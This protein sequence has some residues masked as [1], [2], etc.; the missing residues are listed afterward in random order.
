ML[1][2]EL[3]DPALLDD[4][5]EGGYIRRQIHPKLPL[6][7]LNYT[8]KAQFE[9]VWNDATR[10][11]RGLIYRTDDDGKRE[12]VARPFEKFFNYGETTPPA[13]SEYTSPVVVTDKLDGSLGILY[14]DGYGQ[15]CVA[16]RGSFTS[17]QAIH[18]TGK[19]QEY[20]AKGWEPHEDFTYLWEIVYPENRIV[21]DYRDMDDLVFLGVVHIEQGWTQ[22]PFT[23]WPG[24]RAEVL[25]APTLQ[26][27]IEMQPRPNAEGVVVHFCNSDRRLKIKQADYVELHRIVTGL[28]ERVVWAHLSA[29]RTVAELCEKLPD[30]FHPWVEATAANL[31][32]QWNALW[33]QIQRVYQRITIMDQPATRKDF[34]F[35]A[36]GTSYSA[37]LFRLYDG[38]DIGDMIWAAIKPEAVKGPWQRGEDNA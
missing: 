14:P 34:A 3:I 18:A 31:K 22:G 13:P 32:L 28:N 20:I 21:L 36:L 23:S 16:T 30:D 33:Q 27:A 35:L 38:K 5:I 2:S 8:E 37:Y 6:A 19:L 9:R 15:W 10:K 25:N 29:G 4:M 24:P 12:I 26:A 7:I 11:C 1:L 17:D